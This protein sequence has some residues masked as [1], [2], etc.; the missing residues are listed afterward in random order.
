MMKHSKQ[1]KSMEQFLAIKD[2]CLA[3]LFMTSRR[4]ANEDLSS[5]I[6]HGMAS[7]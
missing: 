7:S 3:V 6:E 1:Q 2:F 4:G 5:V